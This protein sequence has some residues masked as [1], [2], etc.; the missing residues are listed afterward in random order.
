MTSQATKFRGAFIDLDGTLIDHFDALYRCYAEITRAL[1]EPSPSAEAV[2]RNVGGSMPVTIRRFFPEHKVERATELWRE[3][4]ER[5]HLENVVLMP[6]AHE[7]LDALSAK[8][9]QAAVFTN[10]IGRH[11]RNIIEMLELT[12][13]LSFV[14]GAEDTPYRKPEADF[15][16]LA[17]DKLG[18]PGG[19]ALMIGDSP[20]DIEAGRCVGMTTLTV[21]TGSHTREELEAE[22][23]DH[24][25]D[26]LHQVA[27]WIA[28]NA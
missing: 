24:V 17:L 7:L 28:R 12:P 27:D 18:I 19:Q 14:M 15:S 6:G 1:G 4:F 25:F 5:I 13:R 11:S 9:L 2:R 10:K 3:T 8:G 26:D 16:H 22:G 20:F 21:P 23:A